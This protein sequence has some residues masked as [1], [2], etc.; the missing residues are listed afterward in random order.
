MNKILI[1][2]K[3]CTGKTTLFWDLQKY[4]G[5]PM[6]S[7][8]QYL[9]DYIHRHHLT[10]FD[11]DEKSKEVSIDIDSRINA[12]L[13]GPDRVVI[14]A[15]IFGLIERVYPNTLKILLVASDGARIDRAA[16]REK[17]TSEQQ[18]KKLI[19]KEDK[20]IEKIKNIYNRDDF[21]ESKYY[22]VT[23]DTTSMTPEDVMHKVISLL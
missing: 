18:I 3:R 8:G 23:L 14:E 1:S 9:R 22:D 21:F 13:L 2:G 15:R 20:W 16:Y 10:G 12:L 11:V 6:F 17:S 5:W 19:P 7:V 4:L